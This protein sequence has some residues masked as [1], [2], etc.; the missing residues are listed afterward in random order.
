MWK[1]AFANVTLLAA[2]TPNGDLYYVLVRGS[3]THHTYIAFLKMLAEKLDKDYPRW[4]QTSI[5][6]Q[7]NAALHKVQEVDDTIKAL[8]MP[9]FNSAPASFACIP[10]ES[11]F[12]TIKH[13]FREEYEAGLDRLEANHQ[14]MPRGA[15]TQLVYDSIEAAVQKTTTTN[16]RKNYLSQLSKLYL[17][18]QKK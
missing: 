1:Q 6:L 11:T 12:Q 15:K 9:M 14:T 13:R 10:I 16:I 18:L 5:L 3:N 8:K 17:F 7:D 4:R 2:V